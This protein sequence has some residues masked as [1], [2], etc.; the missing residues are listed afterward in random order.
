MCKNLTIRRM[1][2][3]L[4]R[5]K[6]RQKIEGVNVHT[7]KTTG[8]SGIIAPLIL[9]IGTGW[10]ECYSTQPWALQVSQLKSDVFTAFY[11]HVTVHRNKFL[12]NKTN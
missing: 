8:G 10:D 5:Y 11:V 7:R 12:Y 4:G 9:N 6:G 2:R 1:C 3:F